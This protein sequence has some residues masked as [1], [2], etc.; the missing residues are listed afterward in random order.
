MKRH[1]GKIS[2]FKD[3]FEKNVKTQRTVIEFFITVIVL[4][5]RI[6]QQRQNLQIFL[7]F[8]TRSTIV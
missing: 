6:I 7:L 4:M 2:V 5:R 1:K 3:K 8:T